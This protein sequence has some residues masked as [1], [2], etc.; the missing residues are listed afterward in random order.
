MIGE[1]PVFVLSDGLFDFWAVGLD[2]VHDATQKAKS[3]VGNASGLQ[4]NL[5]E[6]LV[7]MAGSLGSKASLFPSDIITSL[8]TMDGGSSVARHH[9]DLVYLAN[10]P[11]ATVIGVGSNIKKRRSAV[12]L[13]L[14]CRLQYESEMIDM[15]E[16]TFDD[17][18]LRVTFKIQRVAVESPLDHALDLAI[19]DE[20]GGVWREP[21]PETEVSKKHN[22]MP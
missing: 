6:H 4:G 16:S 3:F 11:G 10:K 8:R 14:A 20:A 17:L 19:E 22:K 12:M 5:E 9:F 2:S 7:V 18:D 21:I 13:A 15:A 1:I